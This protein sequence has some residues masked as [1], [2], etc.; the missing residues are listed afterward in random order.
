MANGVPINVQVTVNRDLASA[1][2]FLLTELSPVLAQAAK[3]NVTSSVPASVTW[4]R[5]YTPTW[6]SVLGIIGLLVFLLGMLFWL[7]KRE[8][9][10]VASLREEQSATI[11]TFSG[12]GPTELPNL[13]T[14]MDQGRPAPQVEASSAIAPTT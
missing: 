1:H 7:V 5:R 12:T 11:I 9:T 2:D 14:G 3:Y 6:A 4:T 8:D 13:L 10:L